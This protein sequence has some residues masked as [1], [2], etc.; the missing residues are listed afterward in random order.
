L[1]VALGGCVPVAAGLAGV[2]LGPAMLDGHPTDAAADSHF[3]YLSGLLLA[4]GLGFW[5]TI[6]ALPRRTARFRLLT[7]LVLTGGLARLA[8]LPDQ[9]WPGLPMAA[10]LVMELVVTPL[11][12]L[13]QARVAATERDRNAAISG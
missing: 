7:A 11:L 2:I 4:I 9:G 13:W 3:R 12:C 5:S 1:A 8:A 6:P 10:A